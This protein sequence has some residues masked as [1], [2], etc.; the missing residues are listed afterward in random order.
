[1]A[2]QIGKYSLLLLICILAQ[3]LI[4]NYIT[5]FYVAIPIIFI[6]FL[7]RLPINVNKILLFTLAFFTGLCID[8]FSDTPGV[9]AIACVV[10]AALRQPIYYAY[11]E[12]DDHTDSLVPS[13]ATLGMATY[14]KY[15]FT[16][17]VIYCVLAFTI[18]YFSFADVKNIV[19]MSGASALLSF[20]ILLAIDCLIPAKS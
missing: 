17:V 15:L 13:V 19:I 4:F 12:K 16:F 14:C 2:T 8:V 11:V 3:V 10:V 9:N 6:F 7:I 1:M 5:L 20:I 18:E